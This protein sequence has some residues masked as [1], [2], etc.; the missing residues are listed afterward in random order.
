MTR[1]LLVLL[2]LPLPAW[3]FDTSS[4][5]IGFPALQGWGY[6]AGDGRGAVMRSWMWVG[7]DGTINVQ[8]AQRDTGTRVILYPN[9]DGPATGANAEFTVYGMSDQAVGRP[10]QS[11]ERFS[12]TQMNDNER[13]IR[14]SVEQGGS[15]LFR[16]IE[17]CFDTWA[18]NVAWCP[19]RIDPRWGVLV[20]DAAGTCRRI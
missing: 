3:G 8:A 6:D 18:P 16:P 12:L 4:F 10:E 7:P 2:L 9:P 15:G 20:C 17:F 1:L 19:F 13:S 14:F 5:S 11:F